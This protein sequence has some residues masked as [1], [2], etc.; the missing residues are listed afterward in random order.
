NM[1]NSS[2]VARMNVR[3]LDIKERHL[4]DLISK[5]LV[6]CLPECKKYKQTLA[7]IIDKTRTS[8]MDDLKSDVVKISEDDNVA[9]ERIASAAPI[10]ELKKNIDELILIM[11]TKT[12]YTRI[13]TLLLQR[14]N[15]I[16]K[17]ISQ[18]HFVA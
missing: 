11:L 17:L 14:R 5:N 4:M 1:A 8:R 10:L 15:E 3:C 9:L 12:S 16:E 13:H 6:I 2:S 18:F 7:D